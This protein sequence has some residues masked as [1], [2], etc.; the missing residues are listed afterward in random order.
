MT[1]RARRVPGLAAVAAGLLAIILAAEGGA[2]LL[3]YG[4]RWLPD[5]RARADGYA[6][7]DWTRA[8]FRE[9]AAAPLEWRPY[10]YWRHKA[11]SGDYVTIDGD[12]IRRTWRAAGSAGSGPR[13]FALGGSTVWGIG[14]RDD[15]TWPSHLAR[16]LP[17]AVVNLGE[18]G[19]VTA[20]DVLAL[21]ERLDRGDVPAAAIFYGGASDVFAAVQSGR[22]GSPQN[23][24]NREIEFNITQPSAT[25]GIR[26]VLFAGLMRLT[27]GLR[28]G[29][30]AAGP[31][32]TG[33]ALADGVARHYV[34]R[35]RAARALA[36]EYGFTPIFVWQ[37]VVHTKPT[38]T[39]YEER[40]RERFAEVAP[41]Y[42]AVRAR[43]AA[44]PAI[45]GRGD[46]T[47]LSG[48]FAG[49]AHALYI[50]AFHLTEEGYRRVAAALAP[51]AA[52]A[53]GATRPAGS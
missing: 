2:R 43:V 23:E 31:S 26:R 34:S 15:E 30:G 38:R 12:G 35:V 7:A 8:Y 36:R 52:A 13:I 27:A 37:P 32:D 49:D 29:P 42:D 33:I 19:Y 41:L 6:G 25:S 46:W 10:V 47:D 40:Q 28:A 17:A 4:A 11:Y 44:D 48:L 5:P 21:Q 9:L 53:L 3:L 20:Q 50:D 24:A 1:R 22:A 51:T 45:A 14:A 18:H 39:P 16:A